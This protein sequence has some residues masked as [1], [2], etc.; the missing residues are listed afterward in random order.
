MYDS[1]AFSIFT[2]LCSHHPTQNI[3]IIPN[4]NIS[5]T[6]TQKYP[7]NANSPLLSPPSSY[8]LYFLSL[9]IC[10]FYIPYVSG[11]SDIKKTWPQEMCNLFTFCPL[12]F[13]RALAH[14]ASQTRG[15]I[16]AVVAGLC[17]SH[18]NDGS[19]THWARPGIKPTTSWFLVRFISA[20]P[21]WEL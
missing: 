5:Q 1:V 15:L 4:Q 9:W 20:V 3:F 17:H 14:G 19:L 7:W 18:S 12:S 6:Q 2:L 16:G 13:L 8:N 11:I 10:L 21:W